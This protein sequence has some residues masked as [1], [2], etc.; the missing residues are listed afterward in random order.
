MAKRVLPRPR[1]RPEAI[2]LGK[3]RTTAALRRARSEFKPH[4]TRGLKS[5]VTRGSFR[6]CRRWTPRTAR[7]RSARCSI[8]FSSVAS[9]WRMSAATRALSLS[10]AAPPFPIRCGYAEQ[11]AGSLN[12]LARWAVRGAPSRPASP[13][14]D[15]DRPAPAGSGATKSARTSR[16]TTCS[17]PSTG[18]P[19]QTRPVRSATAAASTRTASTTSTRPSRTRRRTRSRRYAGR[20]RPSAPPAP[21]HASVRVPARVCP[22]RDRRALPPLLLTAPSADPP[23]PLLAPPP[24]PPVQSGHVSSIPPY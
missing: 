18:S 22:R 6:A 8:T 5:C 3:P 13:Q 7:W 20:W 10:S 17:A 14:R 15:T 16:R 11:P 9:I 1:N 19:S 2:P 4:N 24:P 12:M 23:P 21:T